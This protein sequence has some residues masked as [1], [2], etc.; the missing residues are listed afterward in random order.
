MLLIK[1]RRIFWYLKIHYSLTLYTVIICDTIRYKAVLYIKYDVEQFNTV[2]R[3]I[4]TTLWSTDAVFWI[5]FSKFYRLKYEIL[6]HV[7]QYSTIQCN[8]VQS[9]TVWQDTADILWYDTIENN[10]TLSCTL[11]QTNL[12]H[13]YYM[14]QGM[15]FIMNQFGIKVQHN[16]NITTDLLQEKFY[17]V[18]CRINAQHSFIISVSCH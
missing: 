8:G 14:K 16:T 10:A 6:G 11:Y 5:F 4:W 12:L 9:D 7:S 1:L 15:Q 3:F 17:M 2:L 18:N 13:K